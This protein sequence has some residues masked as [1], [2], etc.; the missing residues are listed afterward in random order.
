MTGWKRRSPSTSPARSAMRISAPCRCARSSRRPSLPTRRSA[1]PCAPTLSAVFQR[2][3]ACHSYVQAFLFF[4]GFHALQSLSRRAL[5]LAQRT[6]GRG[7]FL[8]EPHLGS[9]RVDIHPGDADRARHHDRS[10]H[11]RRDRRNRGGGRRCLH[12][13]GRDAGR[14]RQG[15]ARIAIPKVRRGVLLSPGAKVL[16]N[17]EIGEYSRVG[18]GSVVL[19]AGAAAHAP[20]PACRRASSARPGQRPSQEMDH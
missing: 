9:F 19:Q 5:A 14:H 18:A 13:A 11:R 15:R 4:K 7:V 6:Q 12:H 17:I 20:S 8:P 2:D 1:P 16:G 10:R 3:P